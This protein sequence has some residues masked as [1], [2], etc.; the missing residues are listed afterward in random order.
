MADNRGDERSQSERDYAKSLEQDIRERVHADKHDR[1]CA[2]RCPPT[3]GIIIAIL[4]I[5][6][7]VL[8]FLDNLGLFHVYDIWRLWPVALIAVGLS[9]MFESQGPGGRVWAGMVMAAGVLFLLDNLGVWHVGWNLIW[10]L[11]L[12][13]VGITMLLHAFERKDL[14]DIG[15]HQGW[16]RSSGADTLREW[17]T[18]GGVK[19]RLNT[20]DFQGGEMI[21]VFGG[22]EVDLREANIPPGKEVVVDANATFGGIELRVPYSW[23]VVT[24]GMGVFGG[25]EDK[26]VPPRPTEGVTA[27][28]LLVTGYAVFG[29]VSIEN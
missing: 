6:A 20:Q 21:A 1:I 16:T 15:G 23:Q 19:R 10:P 9:K 17:A 3:P 28:K 29:G 18:F 14:P 2:R 25:Y 24:R 22:I 12:V 13:G 8:L 5:A 26:T 7:G 11:A 4:I 27:P